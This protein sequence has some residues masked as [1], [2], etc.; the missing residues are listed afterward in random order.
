MNALISAIGEHLSVFST[1]FVL[2]MHGNSFVK[3]RGKSSDIANSPLD[4]ANAS[5]QN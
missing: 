2:R 1:T 4:S 3:I 5:W